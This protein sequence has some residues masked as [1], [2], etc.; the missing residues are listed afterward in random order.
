M[1]SDLRYINLCRVWRCKGRPSISNF[2]GAPI[3]LLSLQV[4]PN[5]SL[6]AT[7]AAGALGWIQWCLIAEVLS[8]WDA[9]KDRN[10]K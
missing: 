8:R 3:S 4:I 5:G 1:G 7:I 9:W 10:H 6:F 2:T